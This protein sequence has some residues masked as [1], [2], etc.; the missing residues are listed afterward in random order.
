MFCYIIISIYVVGSQ[1]AGKM[2]IKRH[3]NGML[4]VDYNIESGTQKVIYFC[5]RVSIDALVIYTW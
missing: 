3:V 1:P 4:E 5:Y 2:M